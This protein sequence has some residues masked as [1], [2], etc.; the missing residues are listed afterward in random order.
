MGQQTIV[1]SRKNRDKPFFALPGPTS[2]GRAF[3]SF[4]LHREA[5]KPEKKKK[6][7]ATLRFGLPLEL[8]LMPTCGVSILVP[9]TVSS[10]A[11]AP[12]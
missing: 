11:G 7:H 3:L 2:L 10:S 4:R 6:R 12:R 1:V 8:Q 9:T 5:M